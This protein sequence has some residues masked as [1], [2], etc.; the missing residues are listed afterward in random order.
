MIKLRITVIFT[1]FSFFSIVSANSIH[2]YNPDFYLTDLDN[3]AGILTVDHSSFPPWAINIGYACQDIYLKNVNNKPFYT[4]INVTNCSVAYADENETTYYTPISIPDGI[5]E[6][7]YSNA[8]ATN[9]VSTW[10]L[11][12]AFN[13]TDNK[14]I[15]NSPTPTITLSL[16]S[17]NS[18]TGIFTLDASSFPSDY[19]SS[20]Y[21]YACQTVELKNINNNHYS[22]GLVIPT[23]TDA[24]TQ[25][26]ATTFFNPTVIPDGEY[27][28]VFP[29]SNPSTLVTQSFQIINGVYSSEDI[30]LSVPLFKQTDNSWGSQVYDSAN[31]WSPLD[32]RIYSWG[33]AMTSAAMVFKYY[34]LNKLPG[35]VDLDPGTLNDWLK[36]QKDGYIGNGNLNWLALARLSKQIAG[37]N[38]VKNFHALEFKKETSSDKNKVIDDLKNNIPDIL[39]V[40][41]HFIVA[42][43]VTNNIISINDPGF[44]RSFLSDYSNTFS[45]INRFT[46]SNTDLSYVMIATQDNINIE[47]QDS[48]GN[49]IGDYFT[50][51]PINN[52]SNLS[53][54][55]GDPL[56][57]VM[58]QK[59]EQQDFNIILDSLTNTNYELG[60]FLYNVDGDVLN[61]NKSGTLLA[62]ES[63][64]FPIHFDSQTEIYP[65]KISFGKFGSDLSKS[66]RNN[67][68]NNSLFNDLNNFLN[69]AETFKRNK[70]E[71][72]ALEELNSFEDLL[73]QNSNSIPQ[74]TYNTLFYDV[75][76]LAT[77]L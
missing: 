34:G 11:S 43:G 76:Y 56:K 12:Q 7:V 37:S 4:N 36:K 23:C 54:N 38:H 51:E 28:L 33:C 20:G 15:S 8:N 35:N 66:Y 17:L 65:R 9:I 5:Y 45:T 14:F 49:K 32:S 55:N 77:H 68:I 62:G 48:L 60:I 72:Q 44:S 30:S 74:D 22:Y 13:V 46:P 53:Q 19:F 10:L 71:A 42:K 52:L 58:L 67:E 6:L 26:D 3:N 61:T 21:S 16:I 27:E 59:P 73:N 1:L 63:Q 29:N 75:N 69:E 50:E 18:N 40:P 64:T 47:L 31:I 25:A 41:G 39:G 24:Y 57:I 2:A 70:Q